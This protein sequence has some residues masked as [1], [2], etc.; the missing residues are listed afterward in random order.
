MCDYLMVQASTPFLETTLATTQRVAVGALRHVRVA[1]DGVPVFIKLGD[2]TVVATVG[3]AGETLVP[4]DG[5]PLKIVTGPA[6]TH[7]A[8]IEARPSAS[9]SVDV[10]G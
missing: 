6:Q 8:I 1:V 10:L 7:L 5:K 2:S 4:P 9:A 3:T